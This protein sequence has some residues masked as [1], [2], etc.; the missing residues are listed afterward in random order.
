L[1]GGGREEGRRGKKRGKEARKKAQRDRIRY[2][3]CDDLF[4]SSSYSSLVFSLFL[5]LSN[6]LITND[7]DPS[8]K[9]DRQIDRRKRKIRKEK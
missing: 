3:I 8:R 2:L 6:P 7:L 1:R 5:P 9:T 4:I